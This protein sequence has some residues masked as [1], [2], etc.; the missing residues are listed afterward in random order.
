[1]ML[2]DSVAP[3]RQAVQFVNKDNAGSQLPHSIQA[4]K[5]VVMLLPVAKSQVRGQMWV[6]LSL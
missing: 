3:R 6:Y 1:M 4:K 2:T 5:P